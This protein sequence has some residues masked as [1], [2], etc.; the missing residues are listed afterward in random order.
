MKQSDEPLHPA[1]QLRR[2]QR[3]AFVEHQ[4]VAILEAHAEELA[5]NIQLV[6]RLLEMHQADLPWVLLLLDHFLQRIRGGAVSA[7]GVKVEEVDLLQ[8]RSSRAWRS[9]LA[10]AVWSCSF[11]EMRA[12]C[13]NKGARRIPTFSALSICARASAYLP[14]A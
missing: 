3:P 7:A 4:V 10:A 13:S 14:F 6:E 9:N 12:A 1:R 8:G 11:S 2:A 5:E